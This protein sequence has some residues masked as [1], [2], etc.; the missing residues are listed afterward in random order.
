[1]SEDTDAALD[2]GTIAPE[3][4]KELEDRCLAAGVDIVRFLKFAGADNF[5]SIA[6]GKLAAV[7]SA[8]TRKESAKLA[9]EDVKW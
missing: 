1:M 6:S 5:A 4:A 2:G 3:K 9:T 7:E 8:L